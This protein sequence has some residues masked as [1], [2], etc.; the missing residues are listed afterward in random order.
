MSKT[1]NVIVVGAGPAGSVAARRSA[2]AGLKTLLIEK[3]PEIG[4]PVRCAEAIGS[5]SAKP[6]ITLDPKWIC[7]EITHFALWNSKRESALFPP[8]EPTLVVDRE[9]FDL[10][11]ANLAVKA[12][13][14]LRTGCAATNVILDKE[15]VTGVEVEVNHR[16]ERIHAKLVVAADGTESQ[17]GRALG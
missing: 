9:L 14:E 13:A 6:Y 16:R 17:V 7:A 2:E 3:R 10:E 1:Y 11:L 4:I 8:A 5:D 12:G 15:M